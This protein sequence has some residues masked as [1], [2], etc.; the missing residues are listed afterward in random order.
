MLA[1]KLKRH[2]ADNQGQQHDQQRQ[3]KT[4]EQ[5]GIPTRKSGKHGAAGRN[6]PDFIAIPMRP[7]GVDDH[8]AVSII[9]A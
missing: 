7:D 3:V 4:A 9:F 6:Q 8:T 2:P 1:A 5:G